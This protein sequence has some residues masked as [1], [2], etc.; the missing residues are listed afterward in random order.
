M[1]LHFSSFLL[2]LRFLWGRCFYFFGSSLLV[3][4]LYLSYLSPSLIL[5]STFSFTP[6]AQ[7]FLISPTLFPH[8]FLHICARAF[9][10]QPVDDQSLRTIAAGCCNLR[11]LSLVNCTAVTD[12]GVSEVAKCCPQLTHLDLSG[13]SKIGEYGDTALQ[14]C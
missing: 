7:A 10:L 11:Y 13:C 4:L 12:T 14:V 9:L 5:S 8:S 6:V 3:F 2:P 1:K